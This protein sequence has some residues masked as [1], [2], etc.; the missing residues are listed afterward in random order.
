MK[1]INYLLFCVS[2]VSF[3]LCYLFITSFNPNTINNKMFILF[4]SFSFSLIFSISLFARSYI[5]PILTRKPVYQ[6]E[7]LSLIRQSLLIS[8]VVTIILFLSSITAMGT[9]DVLL[10]IVSAF[11]FELFF[12]VK[13]PVRG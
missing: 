10:I 3:F 2:S 13:M 4:Y 1:R 6:K 8:F 7:W 9:I 11:I 12:H 5:L